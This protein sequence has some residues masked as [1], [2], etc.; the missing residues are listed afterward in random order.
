MG[1]RWQDK[2]T[3]VHWWYYP[4]SYDEWKG[5][6]EIKVSS[7]LVPHTRACLGGFLPYPRSSNGKIFFFSIEASR[8]LACEAL[9][10]C[11]ALGRTIPA[12]LPRFPSRLSLSLAPPPP[13]LRPP[14][15]SHLCP[16]PAGA[17]SPVGQG[18]PELPVPTAFFTVTARFV[19]DLQK[20][21]EW[22]N[23]EDYM[24]A[25]D[26]RAKEATQAEDEDARSVFGPQVSLPHCRTLI[27]SSSTQNPGPETRRRRCKR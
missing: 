12:A 24:Q 14:S 7:A 22:M 2:M 26:D 1:A 21:N 15:Q 4:D 18:D 19:R 20:F 5:Q 8:I 9:P 25:T 3:R 17:P 6:N 13:H 23:E 11:R 10:F 27:P 16:P